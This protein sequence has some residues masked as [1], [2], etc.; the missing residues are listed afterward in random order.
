[1]FKRILAALGANVFAQVITLVIQILVVPVFLKYWGQ[2]IYGEW[3]VLMALPSYLVVSGSGIGYVSG[4]RIQMHIAANKA[5]EALAVYQ[6]AWVFVTGLSLL[7]LVIIIPVLWFLPVHSWLNVSNI[8][9]PEVRLA[10][11][12]LTLY[13]LLNLQIEIFGGVFRAA[14]QFVRGTY[15]FNFQR[16]FE[17]V[18]VIGLVL[19]G[20][21]VVAVAMAYFLVKFLGI[22]FIL[23]DLRKVRWFSL[24][25]KHAKLSLMRSELFPTVSFMGFPIGNALIVQGMT[26][27]VGIQLGPAAVVQFSVMRTMINLVK[28]FASTIYYSIYPELTGLLATNNVTTAKNLHRYA[29][30]VTLWFV[31]LSTLGLFVLGD[32][33]IFYWTG[34]RVALDHKMFLLLLITTIPN[35]T[36][37]MSSFIPISIN[38]HSGIA[39]IFIFIASI[40]LMVAYFLAPY[41]GLLA[42]PAA[43]FITDFFMLAVVLKQSLK[44]VH[45]PIHEFLTNLFTTFPL[46]QLA[47]LKN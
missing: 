17:S 27:V 5:R 31:V 38:K 45:D 44:I 18:V 37:V 4:N 8:T 23:Y 13:M 7:L 36:W 25:F 47:K 43:L 2:N 3:L 32:W 39:I 16:I 28:Q 20:F 21:K 6:S 24:G 14:G 46:K 22:L 35:A 33:I 29:F 40:S 42:V 9:I 41:I 19:A 30:Q 26:T 10:L 15:I 34:G 11:L 12:F 1:M